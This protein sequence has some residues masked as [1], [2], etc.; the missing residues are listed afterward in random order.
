VSR[1]VVLRLVAD[2]GLPVDL[3]GVLPERL[4]GLAEAEIAGLPLQIGNR[5]VPLGELFR[6]AP[7]DAAHLVVEGATRR[8]DRL[9]AGMAGGTIEAYGDAGAYLGLG[10]R[11][12][13]IGLFGSAG[14]FAGAAMREGVIAV[15]ADAGDFVGASLPGDMHGMAGGA[16]L[17]EG[18]AG[19]RAGDRMR[20]GTIAV[21]GG[22][23]AYPAS[24]MIGGTVVVGGALGAWPGYG[25]RRGTMVLARDPGEGLPAALF[26][27]AG[28][29]DLPWLA[30][31]EGHLRGLGWEG[32]G[33]S[34]RVRRLAGD[35]SVGGR[36]EVLVAA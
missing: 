31:L 21:R 32:G 27:D 22:T 24:R 11:G 14:D 28:E 17:I 5:Q 15:R 18:D 8:L 20:R 4:A 9:G 26:A 2:P 36:G 30:L 16:V 3:T 19:D 13:R 6:V 23:G 25:M 29:H 7:G 34:R 1:P 10:M 33:V 12:G 35:L